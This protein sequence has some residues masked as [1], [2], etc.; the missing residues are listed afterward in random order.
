MKITAK[1]QEIVDRLIS[2]GLTKNVAKSLAVV[3]KDNETRSVDIEHNT[4]LRQPEVSI[5]MQQL[6]RMGW[7]KK[8]DIKKEGKGRPT[9]AYALK[10]SKAAI[11]EEIE[12]GERKKIKDIEKNLESLKKLLA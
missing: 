2:I 4:G 8:R 9:H 6:R 11:L 3:L 1:E 7:I 12:K 5:A 10:K